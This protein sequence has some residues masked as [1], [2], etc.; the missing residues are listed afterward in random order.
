[1]KKPD[2]PTDFAPTVQVMWDAEKQTFSEPAVRTMYPNNNKVLPSSNTRAKTGAVKQTEVTTLKSLILNLKKMSALAIAIWVSLAMHAAILAVKFV[3]EE[4]KKVR[5]NLP[6]LE[7]MLVNAKTK[8]SSEHADVLAQANLDRGG[9]TDENRKMKTALPSPTRK[10]TE[11]TFKP[12]PAAKN[13]TKSAQKQAQEVHEQKRVSEL[14]K[15]ARELLT[16][17]NG[18]HKVDSLTNQQA[19]AAQPDKG[20]QQVLSKSLDRAAL[21]AQA[22]EIDR[23]EALLAKQ[24]DEYQKRPK[25]KFIGARTQEYRFALYVDAWRQKV[26]KIGNL[27]YPEAAKQN[28]LYGQLRLTV[29]IRADGSLE[30]IEIN[31]SSGSKILDEAA[32]HIVEL[33]TP[34][35]SFPD[36]IR[37][38]TDILSVTRTWTFTQDDNLATE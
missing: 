34:Y 36:D 3:P 23:L 17:M 5:D 11:V 28:K 16:Q 20:Q 15:Q 33:G 24:Q 6:T 8:K 2:L 26:E 7:V 25:R 37:K 31:K 27:N 14:E 4:P 19:T 38:D 35:A 10:T 13:S 22:R 9:N 32:R 21:A 1:M 29:S 12:S 18:T 30:G